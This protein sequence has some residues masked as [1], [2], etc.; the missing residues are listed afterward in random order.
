MPLNPGV[1]SSRRLRLFVLAVAAA[2]AGCTTTYPISRD[3]VSW[4]T[5]R[6]YEATSAFADTTRPDQFI[7]TA[8]QVGSPEH[9]ARR[10]DG[11]RPVPEQPADIADLMDVC[12]GE[13]GFTAIEIDVHPSPLPGDLSV[14][15][16][17]D[18]IKPGS[19]SQAARR[20]MRENTLT[21]VLRH[22]VARGYHREGRRVF[23]ELK[24][25]DR[26]LIE[27]TAAAVTA[28][29]GEAD[30]ALIRASI[31]FL[32]FN[33]QAL[34]GLQAVLCSKETEGCG[35]GYYLMSTSNRFPS[36]VFDWF[37]PLPRF[38][39]GVAERLATTSWLTGTVFAPHWIDGFVQSF[40]GIN[41]DRAEHDLP[42]LELHLAV[43]TEPFDDYVERLRKESLDGANALRHVVGLVYELGEGD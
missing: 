37:T 38:D 42:S 2:C 7:D 9:Y 35:H 26:K 4:W 29:D 27:G 16:V 31:G 22:F 15:V 21:R 10:L 28:F 13:L 23:I 11:K 5:Q 33:F 6:Y 8:H 34:A 25:A 36:W 30:A 39:D 19:L 1:T 40:N 18:P 41:R 32:S 17:H 20:Y 24:D 12:F 43:Y 14:V 3:N